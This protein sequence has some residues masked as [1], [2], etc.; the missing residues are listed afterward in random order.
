MVDKR[1]NC[2]GKAPPRREDQMHNP[3]H[4]APGRQH[5]NQH[6]FPQCLA[7]DMIGQNCDT[8][9]LNSGVPDSRH[10]GAPH[11][12]SHMNA[13]LAAVLRFQMPFEVVGFVVRCQCR[14]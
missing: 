1:P 13:L 7:A 11:A 6:S 2:G 4:P 14:Q 3:L 12:W 10:V 9:P 5:A 8:Q